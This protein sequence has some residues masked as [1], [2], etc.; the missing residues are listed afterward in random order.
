MDFLSSLRSEILRPLVT[1]LIPG[2]IA[3]APWWGVLFSWFPSAYNFFSRQPSAA[4]SIILGSSLA[5]GLI[6][7]DLG[8]QLEAKVLD[9][10]LD[11]QTNKRHLIEWNDYLMSNHDGQSNAEHGLS[12][13]MLRFKFELSMVPA[14]LACSIGLVV[15]QQRTSLLGARWWGFVVAS[16]VVA[17]YFLFES[18]ESSQLLA[19]TRRTILAASRARRGQ[20]E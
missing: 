6:L 7:E 19:K 17:L 12:R 1:L 14:A 3:G 11:R 15:L 10:I 18:Y 9:R 13:L 2:V 8:S 20:P 5:A 16:G 4:W